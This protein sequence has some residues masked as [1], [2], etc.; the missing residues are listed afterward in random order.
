[1]FTTNENLFRLFTKFQDGADPT[2]F[3]RLFALAW[4]PVLRAVRSKHSRAREADLEDAVLAAFEFLAR[5]PERYDS[6]QKQLVGFLAFVAE[7][8]LIDQW[9]KEA[10]QGGSRPVASAGYPDGDETSDASVVLSGTF[11]NKPVE[12]AVTK[13]ADPDADTEVEA[14]R[15]LLYGDDPTERFPPQVEE[16]L[17]RVLPEKRDRDLYRLALEGQVVAAD[18]AQLFDM[19]DAPLDEVRQAMKRNR[20]RVESRVR[21]REA[22]LKALLR[23]SDSG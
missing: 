10:R 6:S 3:D 7:R 23:V 8:R 21:R 14:L 17:A 13:V 15:R 2:A 12:D 16:W 11:T 5:H 4:A 20:D 22:E 9:R 18:F 1:M 19:E